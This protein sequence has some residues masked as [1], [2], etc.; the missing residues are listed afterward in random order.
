MSNEEFENAIANGIK[1][2]TW[3]GYKILMIGVIVFILIDILNGGLDKDDT[4]SDSGRSGM[5]LHVD[6]K[7]GCQYLSTS[8]G[9]IKRTD[10]EGNHICS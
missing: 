3:S 5:I 10:M 4:D 6:N 8:G 9:I 7:T 2:A 1:K